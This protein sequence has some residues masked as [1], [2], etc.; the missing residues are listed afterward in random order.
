MLGDKN[1][2]R[3]Q[4]EVRQEIPQEILQENSEKQPDHTFKVV[5]TLN[6]MDQNTKKLTS[7]VTAGCQDIADIAKVKDT[8][9]GI[10]FAQEHEVFQE[11]QERD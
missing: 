8:I 1:T 10:G 5:N 2:F 9:G 4:Q 7:Q 3:N 6:L 11:V